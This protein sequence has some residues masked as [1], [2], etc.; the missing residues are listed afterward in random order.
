M[1]SPV[2]T[3][4]SSIKT[5]Q[6]AADSPTIAEIIQKP[7]RLRHGTRLQPVV[8]R[9]DR[10][11]SRHGLRKLTMNKGLTQDSP[12]RPAVPPQ[13]VRRFSGTAGLELAAR[14][15][16][17]QIS[18]TAWP[19]G[20]FLDG[21]ERGSRARVSATPPSVVLPAVNA[22]DRYA[23][24]RRARRLLGMLRNVA[25]VRAHVFPLGEDV[26]RLHPNRPEGIDRPHRDWPNARRALGRRGLERALLRLAERP[27]A[28]RGPERGYRGRGEGRIV[29][30]RGA[31]FPQDEENAA[32]LAVR[33]SVSG[34]LQRT[35]LGSPTNG[36]AGSARSPSGR[37]A[38]E[39]ALHVAISCG[40]QKVDPADRDLIEALQ[41][42][43]PGQLT[44][45][46][47]LELECSLRRDCPARGC[48]GYAEK[49]AGVT[50]LLPETCLAAG[51]AAPRAQ[52][53]KRQGKNGTGGPAQ[54]GPTLKVAEAQSR[55]S[56]AVEPLTEA[57]RVEL[58]D[59]FEAL[60][61]KFA[62]L[63]GQGAPDVGKSTRRSQPHV[64]ADLSEILRACRTRNSTRWFT[65]RFDGSAALRHQNRCQPRMSRRHDQRVERGECGGDMGF[66]GE[67]SV[68]LPCMPVSARQEHAKE[69][70]RI[71]ESPSES[72]RAGADTETRTA[73]PRRHRASPAARRRP[74]CVERKTQ[75]GG[76]T[77][78]ETHS[79][80]ARTRRRPRIHQ[81][82][83][84][85]R[86]QALASRTGAKA[87]PEWG[88]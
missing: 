40:E 56:S 28:L 11:V 69:F 57:E 18:T 71:V 15:S 48:V 23:A 76:G 81:M 59:G 54:P 63:Q 60:G 29:A 21:R 46:D 85:E 75:G 42:L 3:T 80:G 8:F 44:A 51:R 47:L 33:L 67:N 17:R 77:T 13:Q 30:L 50:P 39:S 41:E 78:T 83:V 72:T 36:D 9:V 52:A 43:K 25:N 86:D 88:G 34:P 37:G 2:I 38:V 35:E 64:G 1:L 61:A 68:L 26:R 74:C 58:R 7:Y 22:M 70:L 73:Q 31:V 49:R 87:R 79:S 84:E 4:Y 5:L 53:R 66:D 12:A 27:G 55:T 14:R 82:S 19:R 6:N 65:F 24:T 45:K 16:H 10:G 62:H 20:W 32:A